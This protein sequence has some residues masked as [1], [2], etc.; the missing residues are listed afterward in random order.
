[1]RDAGG[2]A[3]VEFRE[4]RKMLSSLHVS[5]HDPSGALGIIKKINTQLKRKR[6]PFAALEKVLWQNVEFLL[7]RAQE[8]LSVLQVYW[9][10]PEK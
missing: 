1:L 5:R 10:R 3:F 4:R 6:I 8:K 2:L 9:P 7:S